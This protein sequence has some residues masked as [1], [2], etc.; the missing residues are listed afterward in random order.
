MSYRH[1]RYECQVAEE[2][3]ECEQCGSIR[4]TD[5]ELKQFEKSFKQRDRYRAQDDL[6]R[7]H[8]Y[9]AEA[10]VID[11][12]FLRKNRYPKRGQAYSAEQYV[13]ITG[14]VAE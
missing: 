11:G 2:Y 3:H 14:A 9:L 10:H 12:A 7:P 5:A 13:D 1:E 4:G 6:G 8:K